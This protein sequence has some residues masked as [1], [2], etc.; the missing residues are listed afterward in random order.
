[1]RNRYGSQGA[2]VLVAPESESPVRFVL[3][4]EY[5]I[6]QSFAFSASI[7]SNPTTI[8]FGVAAGRPPLTASAA[9]VNHP[10]LGWSKGMSVDYA[11]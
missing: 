5:R 6:G 11:R 3:A 9:A 7:A 1:V 10:F 4:Q 8:G 2:A